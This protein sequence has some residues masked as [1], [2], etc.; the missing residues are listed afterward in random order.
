MSLDVG[1]PQLIFGLFNPDLTACPFTIPLPAKAYTIPSRYS[2]SHHYSP[3]QKY[4]VSVIERR[5]AFSDGQQQTTG[6]PH[7]GT[8][9]K[10]IQFPPRFAFVWLPLQGIES[11]KQVFH[12]HLNQVVMPQS[13]KVIQQA[14]R[15]FCW[16]CLRRSVQNEPSGNLRALFCDV[17]EN[18]DLSIRLFIRSPSDK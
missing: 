13:I 1:K 18:S 6:M 15:R 9:S 7:A 4:S 11:R 8:V 3:V 16:L 17:Y 12:F 2:K 14:L 5:L 10:A